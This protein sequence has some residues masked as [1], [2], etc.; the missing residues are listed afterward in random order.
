MDTA[1][2]V[3]I[4]LGAIVTIIGLTWLLTGAADY[5]SGRKNGNPALMDQGM[6]SITSGG[7]LAVIAPSIA[8]AIVAAMRA[9][10]F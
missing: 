9:I 8:A 10:S 7:A 1:V 2:R 6:T 5:L 3:V 4:A